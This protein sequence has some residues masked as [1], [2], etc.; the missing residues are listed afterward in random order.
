RTAGD[1]YR[2][3]Q[4]R[5]YR[6]VRAVPNLERAEVREIYARL[7]FEGDMLERIVQTVT[8]DEDVWVAV[9]M[10]HEHQMRPV[11]RRASGLSAVVVGL[12]ALFGSLVPLV[13]FW[14]APLRGATWASMGLAACALFGFGAYKAARTVG[15]PMRG[16]LELAVI[17]M[18]S[19]LV[20]YAVGLAFQA[21]ASP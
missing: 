1:L 10:A 2:G 19:A 11:E 13:P 4:A 3:E 16:G 14:V 21:P 7:G 9:M 6:H 17:G 18:T 8:R 20:G 15:R 12:A 5:E